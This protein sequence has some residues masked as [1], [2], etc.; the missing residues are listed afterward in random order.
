MPPAVPSTA[1]LAAQRKDTAPAEIYD[2]R[3]ANLRQ[4]IAERTNGSHSAFA[5]LLGYRR[6]NIHSFLSEAYNNGRSIGELAARRLE[7]KAEVP[8][9]WLD[10][11]VTVR[12]LK[13]LLPCAL[14]G[15][16]LDVKEEQAK[17]EQFWR[18]HV[19]RSQFDLD[20]NGEFIHKAMRHRLE[21]WLTA[22]SIGQP[23]EGGPL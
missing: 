9:G 18:P 10:R 2:I 14:G 21:G 1:T 12:Q 7:R 15:N 22:R 5:K 3:R 13:I 11:P 17:F 4:L 16:D 6:S 19:P 23:T 8:C 20:A